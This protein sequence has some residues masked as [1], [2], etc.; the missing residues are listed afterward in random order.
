MSGYDQKHGATPLNGNFA[1]ASPG[2]YSKHPQLLANALLESLTASLDLTAGRSGYVWAGNAQYHASR[3]SQPPINF[4]YSSRGLTDAHTQDTA[5]FS[6]GSDHS[7]HGSTALYHDRP[8][9][10][11][12]LPLAIDYRVRQAPEIKSFHPQQGTSGSPVYVHLNS[13]YDILAPPALIISMTFATKRVAAE[14]TR[15]ETTGPFFEY[16]VVS[17]APQYSDTGSLISRVELQLQLQE[18]TGQDAGVVEIGYFE[19]AAGQ[20]QVSPRCATRKRKVSEDSLASTS[21]SYDSY[22]VS[23]GTP[24]AYLTSHHTRD[25]RNMSRAY[26]PHSQFDNQHRYHDPSSAPAAMPLQASMQIPTSQASNWGQSFANLSEQ[27]FINSDTHSLTPPTSD[28]NP[29]LVRTTTLHHSGSSSSTTAAAASSGFNP[30]TYPQKAV[31]KI[32]GDLNTMTEGWTPAERNLKRRLVQFSR[33]QTKNTISATFA[34]VAPEDRLPNSVCISCIWWDERQECFATSVDTIQL[35]EQLVALRFDVEEKNRIRRNLEGFHP[36]TVSKAKADSEEFFKII[37]GFPNPKPRNIEKDVKV[38]PWKIVGHALKK[39]ISKY[40]ASYSSV[41][42]VLSAPRSSI[43][44]QSD[45]SNY[46]EPASRSNS[47]ST[48]S[49]VYAPTFKSQMSPYTE[50]PPSGMLSLANQYDQEHGGYLPSSTTNLTRHQSTPSHH[51][52]SGSATAYSS[53]R[54]RKRSRANTS[55]APIDSQDES[56]AMLDH[57]SRSYSEQPNI[58]RLTGLAEAHTRPL[59]RPGYNMQEQATSGGTQSQIR[60]RGCYDFNNY[61]GTHSIHDGQT[62]Y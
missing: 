17:S 7:S 20:L 37:M 32:H 58:T 52:R 49:G 23:A 44:Y 26:A 6:H 42:G 62:E 31:L 57:M 14:V 60:S 39:I 3:P 40:S 38:F 45:S 27:R 54:H 12:S 48:A 36:E 25:L 13:R 43:H 4:M 28:S 8:A 1:Y 55:N 5:A 11:A 18:E 53:P 22:P 29:I 16:M 10:D 19:Y 30:Y 33:S 56:V 41:T 24:S 51:Y 46:D 21:H 2:P 61:F 35:L 9:Y 59:S 15:L 50:A 47:G 34:P